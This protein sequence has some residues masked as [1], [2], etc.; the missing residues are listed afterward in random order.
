MTNL[1]VGIGIDRHP[2]KEGRKLVLGGIEIDFFLGLDG[3]SDA[4]V[5][6]HAIIDSLLGAASLEDI[7]SHFPETNEWKDVSSLKLLEKT[8]QLLKDH[9]W[10]IVN[11]DAIVVTGLI[12]LSQYRDQMIENLSRTIGIPKDCVG[13]KFKSS[14]GLGFE[15]QEGI[16]ATAVSLISRNSSN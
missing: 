10:Q 4:D 16:S 9:G 14:N 3:H 12:R 1:R 8:I 7:G 11:I 13:I 5:L 6:S 2:F 15:S